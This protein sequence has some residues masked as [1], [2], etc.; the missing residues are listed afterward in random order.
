METV[1]SIRIWKTNSVFSPAAYKAALQSKGPFCRGPEGT[2][3]PDPPLAA[4]LGLP[5]PA[6]GPGHHV[7]PQGHQP[8]PSA[9]GPTL[10]PWGSP[11]LP[12]AQGT[13]S[14]PWGYQPL[15][16]WCR[17]LPHPWVWPCALDGP[18][19]AMSC[20]SLQSCPRHCLLQLLTGPPG[21]SPALA[22][23]LALSGAA[24][25]P[26]HSQPWVTA[27]MGGGTASTEPAGR[28]FCS[29]P[30]CRAPVHSPARL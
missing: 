8:L 15:P 26:Q 22:Q 18:L 7:K 27:S 5:N 19:G 11:T 14:A 4:P 25:G 10:C 13:M 29:L 21:R 9:Q 30:C 24:D 2:S 1:F 28:P 3:G 20:L 16:R 12:T 17:S 6:H 23:S